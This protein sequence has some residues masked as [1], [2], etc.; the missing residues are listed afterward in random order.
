MAYL[1]GQKYCLIIINLRTF[2]SYAGNFS[3]G[4]LILSTGNFIAQWSEDNQTAGNRIF[5]GNIWKNMRDC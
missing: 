3:S 4:P 2:S 1:T 5:S